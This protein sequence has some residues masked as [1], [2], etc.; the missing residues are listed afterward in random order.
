MTSTPEANKLEIIAHKRGVLKKN[1]WGILTSRDTEII[2]AM[3]EAYELG[4]SE[5]EQQVDFVTALQIATSV[6]EKYKADRPKRWRRLD[7]TPILNDLAVR[8]AEIMTNLEPKA[9]EGGKDR[10]G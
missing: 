2:Y 5:N 8:F 4:K 10:D 1:K 6:L 3:R 9:L 7:G